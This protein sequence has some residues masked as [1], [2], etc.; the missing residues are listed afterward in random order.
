MNIYPNVYMFIW[1][2]VYFTI[3]EVYNNL[4]IYT[5]IVLYGYWFIF[6]LFLIVAK[7]HINIKV[8]PYIMFHNDIYG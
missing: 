6:G 5:C 3:I 4:E 7:V 2:I 1:Y 8:I